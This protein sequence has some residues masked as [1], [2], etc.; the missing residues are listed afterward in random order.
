MTRKNSGG[1]WTEIEEVFLL[2]CKVVGV[3]KV[4]PV[5][6]RH[7]EMKIFGVKCAHCTENREC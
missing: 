5:H 7:V 1:Y 2:V 3:C 4:V 6:C